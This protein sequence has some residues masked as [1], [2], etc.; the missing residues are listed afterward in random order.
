M[1]GPQTPILEQCTG[2][3][4]Q[5]NQNQQLQ[6]PYFLPNN[7]DNENHLPPPQQQS[8][9]IGNNINNPG[10]LNGL[11]N[12]NNPGFGS[13]PG[14]KSCSQSTCCELLED[15]DD[16]G[17]HTSCSCE[18][19]EVP[20]TSSERSSSFNSC[21]LPL[22][23]LKGILKKS[24]NKLQQLGQH[25]D[26]EEQFHMHSMTLPRDARFHHMSMTEIVHPVFDQMP[27]CDDCLQ[28]ARRHGSYGDVCQSMNDPLTT[29][30]EE[31][32]FQMQPLT[33]TSNNTQPL[34][35]LPSG[36][37][38]DLDLNFPA[39]N[40]RMMHHNNPTVTEGYCCKHGISTGTSGGSGSLNHNDSL[41]TPS[42][43]IVSRRESFDEKEEVE[44]VESSV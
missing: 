42:L 37:P 12:S 13:N 44:A 15:P 1:G 27:P 2:L 41:R 3:P 26:L 29:P 35:S 22:K 39:N 38:P 34:P 4:N 33:P 18:P 21:T 8:S 30:M 31:C 14:L 40:S 11:P 19:I 16:L 17:V 9:S 10:L 28:R 5:N 32:G 6:Q 25:Q 43:M 7:I 23:P 24:A 20:T 36:L